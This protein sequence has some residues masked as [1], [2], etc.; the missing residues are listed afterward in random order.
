MWHPV[1]CV[2]HVS[3]SPLPTSTPMDKGQSRSAT[4]NVREFTRV[5]DPWIRLASVPFVESV[6]SLQKNSFLPRP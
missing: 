2:W 1:G 4:V 3:P 5:F 6:E